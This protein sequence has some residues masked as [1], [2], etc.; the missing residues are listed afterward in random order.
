MYHCIWTSEKIKNPISYWFYCYEG[1]TS[2]LYEAQV[3]PKIDHFQCDCTLVISFC[4]VLLGNNSQNTLVLPNNCLSAPGS[5]LDFKHAVIINDA[6]IFILKFSRFKLNWFNISPVLFFFIL[7]I[8][9]L[10]LHTKSLKYIGH[11]I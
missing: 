4:F 5:L 1:S 10:V 8:F 11:K 7:F 3:T 9:S 2:D 6:Y